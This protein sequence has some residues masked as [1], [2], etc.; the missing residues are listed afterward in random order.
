MAEL[1]RPE[2]TYAL[3]LAAQALHLLHHRLAKRHISFVE[4]VAAAVL[5]VPPTAPVPPA[6]LMSA[7]LALVA[8]QAAGS[9]WIRRLSP[10]WSPPTGGAAQ[11]RAAARRPRICAAPR[12]DLGC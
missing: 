8:V 3:L 9:L 7:H 12:P 2:A 6:L 1:L 5:L 10:D 11:G 4:V